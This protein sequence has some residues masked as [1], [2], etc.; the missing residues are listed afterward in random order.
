MIRQKL[1]VSIAA[2]LFVWAGGVTSRG[3]D[4]G[5]TKPTLEAM[6]GNSSQIAVV[7]VKSFELDTGKPVP[8]LVRLDFD[9]REILKRPWEMPTKRVAAPSGGA[10]PNAGPDQGAS[11]TA[12]APLSFMGAPLSSLRSYG[13]ADWGYDFT[14]PVGN[15]NRNVA[16]WHEKQSDLLLFQDCT[17]PSVTIQMLIDLG[18]V[19]VIQNDWTTLGD[20]AAVR[21]RILELVKRY[22][23]VDKLRLTF[24]DTSHFAPVVSAMAGRH[25][26][27]LESLGARCLC[28][29]TDADYEKLLLAQIEHPDY[30]HDDHSTLKVAHGEWLRYTRDIYSYDTQPNR[31]LLRK[32]ISDPK[33]GSQQRA[34][35][36]SIL[37]AWQAFTR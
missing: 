28:M 8:A 11:P 3:Q 35:L 6:V 5:I 29:P 10:A 19:G 32:L 33:T 12:I 24:V 16:A 23:G 31:D 1:V 9:V 4:P 27:D 7:R 26:V 17:T 2:S 30:L 21:D 34:L 37:E 20:G 13:Q 15:L 22:R 36:E 18:T 14:A 25:V